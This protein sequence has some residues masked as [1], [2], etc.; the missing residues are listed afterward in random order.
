VAEGNSKGIGCSQSGGV[1]GEPPL[2]A[3]EF[4]ASNE[5]PPLLK[6]AEEGGLTVLWIAVSASLYRETEIAEYQAANNPAKPLNSLE[7]WEQDAELVKSAEKIKEAASQPMNPDQGGSRGSPLTSLQESLVE[8]TR[9][10][11]AAA[12]ARE[13]TWDASSLHLGS[14]IADCL[15]AMRQPLIAEYVRLMMFLEVRKHPE[16]VSALKALPYAH[17]LSTTYWFFVRAYTLYQR[18]QRCEQCGAIEGLEV[19]H[20][21]QE[22]QGTE[23]SHPEDLRVLCRPYCGLL[24]STTKQSHV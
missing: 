2:S 22:H 7:Q 11:E 18:E 16:I 17:S 12:R 13:R 15:E 8:L 5:L 20:I 19:Y 4:I 10:V 14:R 24:Q 23:L 9:K 1:P 21:R 3:S 6:A